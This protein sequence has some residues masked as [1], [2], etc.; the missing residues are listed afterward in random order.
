MDKQHDAFSYDN[1]TR[2]S[3][4][5][6]LSRL[7]HSRNAADLYTENLWQITIPDVWMRRR[8]YLIRML[9]NFSEF[10][11]PQHVGFWSQRVTR[12][13]SAENKED[14]IFDNSFQPA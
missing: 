3:N 6:G 4:N 8:T 10:L 11:N 14:F 2:T 7:P 1:E 13:G 5:G 12:A 9:L